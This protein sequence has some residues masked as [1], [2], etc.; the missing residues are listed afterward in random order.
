M[1]ILVRGT[2]WIGDAVMTIPAIGALR[3]SFP[4]A[5][6]TLLT[7][8]TTIGIFGA[9]GLFDEIIPVRSFLQQI[10]TL[11]RYHFDLAVVFPNSFQSALVAFLSGAT[12]RFGYAA[13]HRSFL[14]TDAIALPDWKETRHEVFY[15]RNLVDAVRQSYAG[16]A[17]EN[18]E[19][20]S[21]IEIPASD[22][23]M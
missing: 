2:N 1:K 9:T 19:A 12:R 4:D 16:S 18:D 8:E 13:Q 7:P 23:A 21:R 14:L 3:R 6:L 17:S 10:R 15:Y 5:R 22:R 20:G 11:R